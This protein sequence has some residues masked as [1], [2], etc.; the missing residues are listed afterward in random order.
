VLLVD[1]WELLDDNS[2]GV[3][4]LH[5][6]A[7]NKL[8]RQGERVAQVSPTTVDELADCFSYDRHELADCL[9]K[10]VPTKYPP[11]DDSLDE[12]VIHDALQ[13]ATR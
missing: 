6:W 3:R 12:N 11:D 1:L 4:P 2:A 13:T 7:H 9:A 10:F 8:R 5:P